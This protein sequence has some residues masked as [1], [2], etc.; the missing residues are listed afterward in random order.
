MT[1]F[2]LALTVG[3]SVDACTRPPYID[4]AANGAVIRAAR[5]G[6]YTKEVMTKKDPDTLVADD[7]TICRVPPDR[8]KS[9][10]AHTLVYCNWQ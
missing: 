1:R 4:P 9:T 7:L 3:I 2:A 5:L 6:L 10:Q 8:Y